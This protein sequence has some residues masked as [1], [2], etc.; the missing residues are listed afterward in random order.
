VKAENPEFRS[1]NK[2]CW[3]RKKTVHDLMKKRE[4]LAAL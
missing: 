2:D 1:K 4:S 3:M